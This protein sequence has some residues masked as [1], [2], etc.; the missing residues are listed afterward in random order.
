MAGIYTYTLC[1]LSVTFVLFLDLFGVKQLSMQ[2]MKPLDTWLNVRHKHLDF[3]LQLFN[4]FL[5]NAT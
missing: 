1:R 5:C 2:L 3:N 4:P